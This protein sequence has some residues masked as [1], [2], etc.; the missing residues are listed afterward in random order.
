MSTDDFFETLPQFADFSSLTDE[1][2]YSE[3]PDDW[4]VVITDIKDST[5]AIESGRYRDIN[6]VGAASIIVVQNA[7]KNFAFPYTF[8]G[9]GASIL[10]PSKWVDDVARSLIGLQKLAKMEFGLELRIGMVPV[11]DIKNSKGVILV[12]KFAINPNKCIAFFRGGG[13]SL[14]E[15]LIKDGDGSYHLKGD[16]SS[17]DLDGLSCRWQP[18]K[19]KRGK[20]LSILIRNRE[21]SDFSELKS[22]V[23]EM[24][25]IFGGKIENANPVETKLMKYKSL[26]QCFRDEIRYSD[27]KLSKILLKRLVFMIF[28]VFIFRFRFPAFGFSRNEYLEELGSHSDFRKFD[29]IVRMVVDCTKEQANRISILLNKKYVERKIFYGLF[30]SD[31]SLMTCFVQNLAAGGHIHFIDGGDG[32]YAMAAKQLKE[33]I[34]REAGSSRPSH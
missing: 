16:A 19:S 31:T 9:D 13:F 23:E 8:G 20:I 29:E 11:K 1:R 25:K 26:I 17:A 27:K 6:T 34:K 15:K 10:I 2:H 18:I 21:T 4:H 22:I 5:R 3:V 30:S 12:G 33:Q 28:A 14:A 7:V 32:G 24:E